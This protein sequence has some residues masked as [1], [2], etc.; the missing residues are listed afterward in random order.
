M[1][2]IGITGNIAT[3]KTTVARIFKDIGISVVSSD[4]LIRN[5]Q[6]PGNILWLRIKKKWGDKYFKADYTLNREKVAVDLLR[7]NEF[8]VQLEDLTH[9]V[10][11]QKIVEMFSIWKDEGKDIVAAEVPLLFEAGWE[12]LFDKIILTVV[13]REIQIKRIVEK[14]SI[15]IET[16][17]EWIKIQM[18]W[19][20][21][22]QKADAVINTE[23]SIEETR[24]I[25]EEFVR[26]I[27]ENQ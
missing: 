26:R 14:R 9:P 2:K 12:D 27:Y 3:G 8:K 10:I 1:L 22:K 23:G 18:P 6:N 5:L 21:K 4:E 11:K 15:D 17:K 7:N 13:S 20:M 25:L 24:S 19:D 16:A